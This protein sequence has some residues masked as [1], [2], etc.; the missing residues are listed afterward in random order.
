MKSF[1]PGPD[2]ERDLRTAFG[3]FATGVTVVTTHSEIGPLGIVANSFSSVSLDPALVLWCV[4]KSSRRYG[5]FANAKHFAIHVIAAD[6]KALVDRFARSGHDFEG[7]DWSLGQN[8]TPLLNTCAA[9]FECDTYA[10]H[11]AGDHDIILGK[12]TSAACVDCDGLVFSRGA[13]QTP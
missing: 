13:F 4:A 12:I 5:A 7:V 1:V 10:I 11:E 2:S 8:D 9:R 6:Q 3:A